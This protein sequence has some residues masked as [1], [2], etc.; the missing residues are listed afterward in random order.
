ME[1]QRVFLAIALSLGVLFAWQYLFTPP[2]EAPEKGV[3]ADAGQAPGQ[4]APGDQSPGGARPDGAQVP[5]DAGTPG[6]PAAPQ[7]VIALA[8][9][10]VLTSANFRATFTNKGGRLKHFEILKPDQYAPRGDLIKPRPVDEETPVGETWLKYLPFGMV[11]SGALPNLSEETMYEVASKTDQGVVFRHEVAGAYA[12][13]KRFV[14]DKASPNGFR[15]EV[16]I[17][18]KST[19]Q[20]TDHLKVRLYGYEHHED[21]E[22]SLFDP[23]PDIVEALCHVDGDDE[24]AARADAEEGVKVDG[25]AIWGGIDSRYFLM[26]LLADPKG[27]DQAEGAGALAS[28]HFSLHEGEFLRSEL[29]L[30][31]FTLAPGERRSWQFGTYLGPKLVETLE[32]Y[33]VQLE[34]SVDYG[35]FA[36]LCKPIRWLLILFQGWVG[37]WG[38]AIILLT[39][40]LRMLTFPINHSAYKNMEGMRRIQEPMT[41]LREKYKDDPMKQQELM[42]KLYKDEGV[43]PLGCVPQLLQIPIFFALYTTIYSSVEI[44]HAGFV[45]WYTDLSAP[46]PYFVLPVLVTL[47]MTGQQFMMPQ[48]T[49]NPQMKIVMWVMPIMFG[50]FTFVLP[51]GLGLYML[52]SIGLGITQQYFI[53][54]SFEKKQQQ[55]QA[56]AA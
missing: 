34:E 28:C 56:A 49:T 1:Q 8:E 11:G 9:D 44:Y 15:F 10:L 47:V 18:N 40:F 31:G 5:G 45:G 12:L 6:Q 36:F 35:I 23:M 30:G 25:P 3:G 16:S 38:V 42:M 26:A 19:L 32:T 55:Q 50:V 52:V 14:L 51:S 33:G 53:R 27:A 39:F 4:Q 29:G 7:R 46:D 13:E 21:G 37:N 22:W 20:L 2:P 43:S 48:T 24:R 17:E 41:A 54:K